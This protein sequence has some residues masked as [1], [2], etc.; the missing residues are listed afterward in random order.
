MAQSRSS[1]GFF[2]I[3][4]LGIIMS[5][6]SIPDGETASQPLPPPPPRIIQVVP[7]APQFPTAKS[8]PLPDSQ[9]PSGNYTEPR[10]AEGTDRDSEYLGAAVEF[11]VIDYGAVGDGATND[12]EVYILDRKTQSRA[13]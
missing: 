1:L 12:S 6:W 13:S 10:P 9:F 3:F 4:L 2:G 7:S 8:P 5:S 11:N